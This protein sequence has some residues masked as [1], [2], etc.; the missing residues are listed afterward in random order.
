MLCEAGLEAGH[1]D[2][3]LKLMEVESLDGVAD[4]LGRG[5]ESY[6]RVEAFMRAAESYGIGDRLRFDISVVRGL[7]YYTGIVFEG[8]DAGR[9]LR[10]IF[11]GGRY[12]NLLSDVGGSSTTAVGL[13]FGD[14]VIAELLAGGGSAPV[15]DAPPLTAVGYM[16][17]AQADTAAAV[18]RGLRGRGRNVDMAL[19]PEKAKRFFSRV[20]K[21][22]CRE[23]MYIGPDDV[24]CG[25]VR[26]KN[27]ADRV[28]HELSIAELT[29][30]G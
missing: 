9:E 28:E 20:G 5:R 7:A 8:F 21:T 11:G 16:D 26:M 3:I 1:V 12:D 14:V 29:E 18:A 15:R 2:G 17:D 30:P 27:L 19:S 13:G 4:L 24:A 25:R 6:L 10:A 22:C 23:A